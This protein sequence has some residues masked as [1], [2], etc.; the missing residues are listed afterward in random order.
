MTIK[1][2]FKIIYINPFFYL[3]GV[4]S[5]ITGLFKSFLTMYLIVFIHELGHIIMALIFNYK[6]K[7][8][9]I[10]PFGGYTIFENNIS[11]TFIKEFMVFLGGILFQMI[12][13]II[14]SIFIDKNT[15]FY[16][17]FNNYNTSILLFNLLPIIPLDGG[18]LLNILLNKLFPFK[19][20]NK[21]SIYFSYVCS[22]I[23][24]IIFYNNINMILMSILLITLIINENKNIK[25][26]FNAFLLERYIKDIKFKNNNF[27]NNN[28]IFKMKKYL[29]NIFII[30]NRYVSE[31]EVLSKY[32]N[33]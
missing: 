17:I 13:F 28:N 31:K 2:I 11:N 29:N 16:N 32:F 12:F 20:S 1:N 5:I 7:K 22:L 15:Y 25:F 26:L 27:I 4:I 21:I 33:N 24:I 8:I 9:N 14:I 10:Y 3:F 23:M 30:N 19:L 6:I 18:K